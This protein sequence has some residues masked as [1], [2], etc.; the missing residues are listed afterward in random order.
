MMMF[1]ATKFWDGSTIETATGFVPR[2][3]VLP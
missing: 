2:N 1:K 3:G